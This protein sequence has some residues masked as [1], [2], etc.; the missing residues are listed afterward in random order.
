MDMSSMIVLFLVPLA[1][2][3]FLYTHIGI[4]L[5]RSSNNNMPTSTP[6]PSAES[7]S[8]SDYYREPDTNIVQTVNLTLLP[9]ATATSQCLNNRPATLNSFSPHP[10]KRSLLP[11]P[12]T[13]LQCRIK[14]RKKKSTNKKSTLR[15]HSKAAQTPSL[16]CKLGGNV[17]GNGQDFLMN[18]KACQKPYIHQSHLQE[19]LETTSFIQGGHYQENTVE[20]VKSDSPVSSCC[21]GRKRFCRKSEKAGTF[22][23]NPPSPFCDRTCTCLEASKT[24][25]IVLV[26]FEKQN[27]TNKNGRKGQC[28]ILINTKSC[29]GTTT[30]C[31]HGKHGGCS[32][33]NGT[34]GDSPLTISPSPPRCEYTDA[35]QLGHE[36]CRE[37]G[38][39]VPL[40]HFAGNGSV[41]RGQNHKNYSL[42]HKRNLSDDSGIS[43]QGRHHDG[44]LCS[45]ENHNEGACAATCPSCGISCVESQQLSKCHQHFPSPKIL[46]P[47]AA[48]VPKRVRRMRITRSNKYGTGA[49]QSRRRIIRMLIVVVLAFA[50]C[51]LPFHARKV[52]QYWSPKWAQYQAGS[53]FSTMFT[54]ITFLIMYANSAINPLLYAFMSKKFRMSF[55]DLLCC[56]MRHSLR[57]S[58]NASVRST[59]ALALSQSVPGL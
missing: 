55:K 59:H 16:E 57:M 28:T 6:T 38:N 12:F 26:K 22:T 46:P 36:C 47:L 53:F 31:R 21:G 14:S 29:H 40:V 50:L 4:V 34:E 2:I 5:W 48:N 20:E 37:T 24:E 7:I 58:R 23:T 30:P 49:L 17:T 3:T 11:S 39:D 8:S 32:I 19:G 56:R 10:E 41:C 45:C 51:H 18:C 9:V 25:P 33:E 54:P 27:Q 1:I 52:W 15:Q 43:T 44:S 42:E 13:C 35:H